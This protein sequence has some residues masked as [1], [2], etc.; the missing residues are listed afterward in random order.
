MKFAAFIPYWFLEKVGLL[1]GWLAFIIPNQTRKVAHKNIELCFPDLQEKERLSLTRR[2]L[3]GMVLT[4]LETCHIWNRHV[5][6]SL[7]KILHVYGEDDLKK[8]MELGNGVILAA[9]HFGSWE[10]LGLWCAKRYPSSYLYRP[11]KLQKFEDY[12][13]SARSRNGAKIVPTNA[14]GIRKMFQSLKKGELVGILPD[15]D[16]SEG[17]GM[18]VPF[19]GIEANTMVLLS[20]FAAKTGARVFIAYAERVLG[21]GYILHIE[22]LADEINSAET[23]QSALC[24]NKGIEDAVKRHPAQYQWG[25]KRFKRRPKGEPSFYNF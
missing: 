18:F 21:K 6:L 1:L 24:L 17:D 13:V 9:P 5:D 14:V 20:R 15:Q 10:I 23:Y 22:P 3:Q 8:A 12:M 4:I 19:F 2:S 25:Y 7:D 11:P 16:P